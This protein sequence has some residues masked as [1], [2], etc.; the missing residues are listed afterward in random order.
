ML[1]VKD[2]VDNWACWSVRY[3]SVMTFM[4]CNSSSA[5]MPS[6]QKLKQTWCVRVHVHLCKPSSW[7]SS[8][9]FTT[10][11]AWLKR[12]WSWVPKSNVNLQK[13]TGRVNKKIRMFWIS[14]CFKPLDY[15]TVD[16]DRT[17]AII[18]AGPANH[19]VNE[20]RRCF[21]A[22]AFTCLCLCLLLQGWTRAQQKLSVH[23]PRATPQQCTAH[24]SEGRAHIHHGR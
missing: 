10:A 24:S 7:A 8:L 15:P 1:P 17:E 4:C 6:G 19:S 14:L 2:Q 12:W 20:L 5:V 23:H 18:S 9:C 16:L 11:D 22:L 3:H 21:S 13:Y